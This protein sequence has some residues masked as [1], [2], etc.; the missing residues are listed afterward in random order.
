M[1]RASTLVELLIALA[2]IAIIA[3]VA[4]GIFP[5]PTV[6]IH[7]GDD[8]PALSLT[9]DSTDAACQAIKELEA[10]YASTAPDVALFRFD[11]VIIN[12]LQFTHATTTGCNCPGV[13]RIFG[14]DQ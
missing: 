2:I 9:Y 13:R 1:K 4:T 8:D 14:S 3:V 11:G 10:I 6:N 7:Y 12:H 5:D